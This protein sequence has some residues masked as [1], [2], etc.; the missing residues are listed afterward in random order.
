M[1]APAAETVEETADLGEAFRQLGDLIVRLALPRPL[2][3]S[4]HGPATLRWSSQ[5]AME[6]EHGSSQHLEIL[7]SADAFQTWHTALDAEP[8]VAEFVGPRTHVAALARTTSVPILL[9]TNGRLGGV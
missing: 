4:A 7:V 9:R 3:V 8:P 5:V 6:R 2:N 1:S